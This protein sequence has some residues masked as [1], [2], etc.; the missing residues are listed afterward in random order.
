MTTYTTWPFGTDAIETDPL[1]KLR[2][3]VVTTFNPRWRYIAAYLGTS[4][5]TGNTFDPPW[6]FASAERPTDTEAKMLAS[7]IQEHRNHWVGYGVGRRMDQRPLDIDAASDTTVFIKYGLDDWGYRNCMWTSGS[8]FVPDPPTH[9]AR[10]L[11]PLTLE[12]VMD[13]THTIVD[14]P[15]PHWATWKTSHPDIFGGES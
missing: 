4:A 10:K 2:I 8:T 14:Q 12:Q 11:G 3:P 7:Y 9:R 1:T 15:M 5:D 13:R 6:P